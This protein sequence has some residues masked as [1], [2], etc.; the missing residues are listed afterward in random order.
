MNK[1]TVA[2]ESK[3]DSD[4]IM[5]MLKVLS[6]MRQSEVSSAHAKLSPTDLQIREADKDLEL[7]NS[8]STEVWGKLPSEIRMQIT[9]LMNN[10]LL[11][12]DAFKQVI[13]ATY[14][15]ILPGRTRHLDIPT[16]ASMHRVREQ[17][18]MA[19]QR[20]KCLDLMR[21][22]Q[23]GLA[24]DM[25]GRGVLDVEGHAWV[26]AVSHG[27]G[28]LFNCSQSLPGYR[29]A[30]ESVK[31]ARKGKNDKIKLDVKGVTVLKL[32][33][34]LL[35]YWLALALWA[36]SVEDALE[37]LRLFALPSIIARTDEPTRSAIKEILLEPLNQNVSKAL[38][39]KPKERCWRGRFSSAVHDIRLYRAGTPMIRLIYN[40]RNRAGRSDPENWAYHFLPGFDCSGRW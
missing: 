29:E 13:I 19:A 40:G 26:V 33:P 18:S 7:I 37:C 38:K 5:R 11:C 17:L 16:L 30:L 3:A 2:S 31:Q 15:A 39:I 9:I 4:M 22:L 24:E 25:A 32:A 34:A 20:M 36:M 28:G 12:P 10:G 1:E 8:V 35:E 23:K 27:L 14:E 6:D 21:A